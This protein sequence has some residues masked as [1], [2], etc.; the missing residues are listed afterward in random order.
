MVCVVNTGS[1]LGLDPETD[2]GVAERS[3]ELCGPR[4]FEWVVT[5]QLGRHQRSADDGS[6]GA[7]NLRDYYAASRQE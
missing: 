2:A 6:P 5:S 4:I 3:A 7:E 1:V